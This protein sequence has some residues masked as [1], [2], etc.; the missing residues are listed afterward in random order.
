[1]EQNCPGF[2]FVLGRSR[3]PSKNG[4]RCVEYGPA[5]RGSR[6]LHCGIIGL[7]P[8]CTIPSPLQG[9]SFGESFQGTDCHV[10]TL[11]AMTVRVLKFR[12]TPGHIQLGFAW[13]QRHS[14]RRVRTTPL[15]AV[16]LSPL[17][18]RLREVSAFPLRGIYSIF[19]D[20][21]QLHFCKKPVFSDRIWW[22][23]AI[24]KPIIFTRRYSYTYTE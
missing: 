14:F 5:C 22:R 1:M 17:L 3:A 12:G 2:D 20:V 6:N 24:R 11:L 4:D 21:Q 10:A 23:Y 18:W 7:L 15:P 9:N 16:L 13:D 19:P 8:Y